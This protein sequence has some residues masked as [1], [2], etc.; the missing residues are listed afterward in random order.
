MK[1]KPRFI[2]I[3]ILLTFLS[4]IAPLNAQ[5]PHKHEAKKYTL[6]VVPQSPPVEI[7]K[8]WTPFVE[9]LSKETGMSIQLKVYQSFQQF[10]ADVM[11]GVPDFAFM[12]PY[13]VVIAK[14]AH[15]YIPLVRDKKHIKGIIVVHKDS[16]IQSVEEL[17]NKEMALV[18]PK[19]IC[20]ILLN[21][22]LS[23]DKGKINFI[24]RYMGTANNVYRNVILWKTPAGGTL[25]TSLNREPAE[26]GAQ[27]RIIYETSPIAPHSLA[28]HPRVPKNIYQAVI[29]AVLKLS[30]DKTNH[31]MLDRIQMLEPVKASYQNDYMPIEK[32][33][34]DKNIK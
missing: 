2:K 18:S 24:A 3:I 11:S 32:L 22:E 5:E 27:L 6:A 13:Q 14:N 10:E 20:S 9:T 15:G 26:I 8:R 4:L 16:P 25:D 28:V 19:T 33:S 34:S 7:Y 1:W 29:N 12:N 23:T 17:N 21:H 30:Q 31:G